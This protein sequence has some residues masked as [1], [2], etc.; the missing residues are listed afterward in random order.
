MSLQESMIAKVA[1]GAMSM[2]SEAMAKVKPE[3]EVA[4][5][6]DHNIG[7]LSQTKADDG[8]GVAFGLLQKLSVMEAN[9]DPEFALSKL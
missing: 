9:T 8:S 3:N 4:E 6:I 1:P 2:V 7:I 5:F